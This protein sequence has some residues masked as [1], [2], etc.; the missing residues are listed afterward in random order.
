MLFVFLAMVLSQPV[1]SDLDEGLQKKLKLANISAGWIEG[2]GNAI[3]GEWINYN[4]LRNDVG[5][6][7]LTRATTGTKTIIWETQVIPADWAQKK[8]TFLWLSGMDLNNGP[9]QFTLYIN[10][11]ARFDFFNNNGDDWTV[12]GNNGGQLSFTV[13]KKDQHKDGFGYM[14]MTIPSDWCQKGKPLE[15]KVVGAAE[16]S[17]GWYMVFEAPDALNHLQN[18]TRYEGWLVLSIRRKKDKERIHVQTSPNWSD[19]TFK[20]IS[21]GR[22]LGSCFLKEIENYGLGDIRISKKNL[23]PTAP[24]QVQIED[25]TVTQFPGFFTSVSNRQLRAETVVMNVTNVTEDGMWQIRS[26][27]FYRPK[28]IKNLS[29]ISRSEL[30]RGSVFLMNSSHQ[31]IAW[32]DSP[33]KCIIERDT[34]LITPLL[35]KAVVD[36]NYRF[37]I[38]DVLMVEEYLQRHPGKKD[39]F[40]KLLL[41]GKI[42]VGASYSMPYEDMYSGESLVRQF[43]FG[44][45]WLEKE[46]PGYRTNTYWNVDVPGRTLQ[47][48]QI[49]KK[50]GIPNLVLSRQKAGVYN[51]YSPD[52]S[53]ATVFS[54]GH[55][56]LA[57]PAL[58]G[59][60]FDAAF[61]LSEY[62][63]QWIEVEDENGQPAIPLLSDWDMSPAKDYSGFIQGW[64]EMDTYIDK[65]GMVREL[66]L[67]GIRLALT[68]SYFKTLNKESLAVPIKGERPNVWLYI[69]GPSH[70]KALKASR[71][72]DILLPA[73]EK[74]ATIDALLNG[75]FNKYPNDAFE[76][77]WKA[78]IFPDHGWGGKHGDITDALFKSKFE[79]SRNIARKLLNQ[80]VGSIASRIQTQENRGR[81]I[82]IFNDL[83]WARTDPVSVNIRF[84]QGEAFSFEIRSINGESIPAQISTLEKHVNGSVKTALT[85]FIAPDIPPVGYKTFYVKPSSTPFKEHSILYTGSEIDGT[86]YKIQLDHGGIRQIFDKEL[87]KDLIRSEVYKAGE[88]ILMTSVG[89][90]AGEFAD[91]QKPDPTGM[92]KTGD[93]KTE[94]QMLADG[95]VFSSYQYRQQ[96]KHAVVQQTIRIFKS[97]KRIDFETELLNWDGTLYKE[98]RQTFPVDMDHPKVTYEVPFGIVRV[99]VDELQEAAGERY[100]TP[101]P[102]MHPRS[103]LNWM[104]ASDEQF[105][106]TI[107]SSVVA[108]DYLDPKNTT[109][110]A[111]VLQ[112]ILIASR[113][114]CHGEGNEYLQTGNHR[115]SF[116]FTSH[117]PGWNNGYKSGVQ[118]NH[119][120]IAV[121][122][123]IPYQ[124]AALPESLAFFSVANGNVVITAIKKCEDDTGV[125][126]RWYETEGKNTR[127]KLNS[128]FSITKAEHTDMIERPL[129]KLVPEPYS[130][131]LNT[132]GYGIETLKLKF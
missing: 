34:M 81:P 28:L 21:N 62:A 89:N 4:S 23:N 98:F 92:V 14:W 65:D 106:V 85:T 71:E 87:G 105:G 114:S 8:I 42:S 47:M 99:G 118:A 2:Y 75:S 93:Y 88:I 24:V 94:W 67:P 77:A 13:L 72:G 126:I 39:I 76:K 80:S 45:K 61:F 107:S 9:N 129:K 15:L 128:Y 125:I 41:K 132:A 10:D 12:S 108:W 59:D 102:E 6:A 112:P 43:Y 113:R 91:I 86:Y 53:F 17:T 31:D 3:A 109:G 46:F 54:P 51:W 82:V 52:G 40:H 83:S 69:H 124:N 79:Q 123:P 32:M 22:L 120:L 97:L 7:L 11:R 95:P 73:A 58:N 96:I 49:M 55:Y 20:L 122:D 115:F 66:S 25:Q 30:S 64:E 27:V 18:E 29:N 48:P 50:S 36:P 103:I 117:K 90:G 74:F 60:F 33:E 68:D 101:C 111:N 130:V 131:V 57:Y 119:H 1:F 38:E 116:S 78:K 70:Q 5:K 19:K 37:D 63:N 16:N 110:P 44:K 104:S 26:N 35:G 84:S 127:A 56:S 100:L 121:V